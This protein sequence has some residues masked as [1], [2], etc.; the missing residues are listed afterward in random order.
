M[1]SVIEERKKGDF[2]NFEDIAKR[3]PGFYHPEKHISKR[4]ELELK[5]RMQ[6]YHLFTTR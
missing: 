5:D 1:W 4:I 2:K 6:K 3:V